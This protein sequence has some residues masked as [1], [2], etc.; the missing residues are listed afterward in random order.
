MP[1]HYTTFVLC[2]FVAALCLWAAI[3]QLENGS[4]NRAVLQGFLAGVNIMCAFLNWL[5]SDYD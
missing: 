5:L 3:W 4:P 1:S 2:S